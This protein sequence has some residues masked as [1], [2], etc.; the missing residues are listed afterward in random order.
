MVCFGRQDRGVMIREVMIV[1]KF[2]I[3]LIVAAPV[4]VLGNAPVAV[5]KGSARD[6][7]TIGWYEDA[8]STTLTAPSVRAGRMMG[9]PLQNLFRQERRSI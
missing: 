1:K 2:C 7:V 8:T 6:S 3:L 4:M 5:A 9:L